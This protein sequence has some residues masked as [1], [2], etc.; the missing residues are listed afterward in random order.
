MHGDLSP[1]DRLLAASYSF[2]TVLWMVS[3]REFV[4]PQFRPPERKG[5][6]SGKEALGG[7]QGV[8]Q[9]AAGPAFNSDPTFGCRQRTYS[10]QRLRDAER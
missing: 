5:L 8:M 10:C 7:E 2:C 4:D 3:I 9:N 1:A 6:A